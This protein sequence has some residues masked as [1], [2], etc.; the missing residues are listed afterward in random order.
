VS[1]AAQVYRVWSEGE[2]LNLRPLPPEGE[3]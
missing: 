1:F 3:L 2:D